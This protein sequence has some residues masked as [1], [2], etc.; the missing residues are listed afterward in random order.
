LYALTGLAAG[1][2]I[3]VGG[4]AV[5]GLFGIP[6]GLEHEAQVSVLALG[7]LT[8]VGWPMKVFQD[9]LRGSQLFVA[10]ATAEGA[11]VAVVAVALIGLAVGGA[12]LWILVAAGA[13]VPLVTGALSAVVVALK[14]LPYRFKR[15][16]VSRDSARGFL[17][18]SGYLFVGGIADL[19]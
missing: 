14:R 13:S 17:G 2:L 5:L 6:P 3:A 7:A 10:S 19:V 12:A 15:K 18:L 9:V 16:A 1:G 4:T 8:V 11:A